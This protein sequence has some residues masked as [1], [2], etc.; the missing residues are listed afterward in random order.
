M[1]V[2]NDGNEALV[3]IAAKQVGDIQFRF[4]DPSAE[5]VRNYRAPDLV[6]VE[7]KFA[8][9]AGRVTATGRVSGRP[10]SEVRRTGW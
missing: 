2:F 3:M 6:A 5:I 7:V 10:W 1:A 4:D 9:G 8:A